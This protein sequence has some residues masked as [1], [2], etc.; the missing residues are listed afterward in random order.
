V[1]GKEVVGGEVLGGEV[2]GG[3]VLGGVTLENW[4]ERG[5]Y[6]GEVLRQLL[7]CSPVAKEGVGV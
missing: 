5:G 2:V 3:E 1:V 4:L 7:H 6:L